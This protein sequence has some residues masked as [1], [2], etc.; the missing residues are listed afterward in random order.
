MSTERTTRGTNTT[1]VFV[2]VKLLMGME[3]YLFS[4]SSDNRIFLSLVYPRYPVVL[5]EIPPKFGHPG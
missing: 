5:D 2:V 3:I 1:C 4:S